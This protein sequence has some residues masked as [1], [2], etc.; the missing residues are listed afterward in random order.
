MSNSKT[1]VDSKRDAVEERTEQT[2]EGEDR[3][4]ANTKEVQEGRAY[5]AGSVSRAGGGKLEVKFFGGSSFL[6]DPI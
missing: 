2:K 4:R 3:G 5:R 6:G 1:Q